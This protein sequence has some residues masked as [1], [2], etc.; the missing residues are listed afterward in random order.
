MHGLMRGQWRSAQVHER[1]WVCKL[2]SEAD[3]AEML[4][5]ASRGNSPLLYSTV[6]RC[7]LARLVFSERL[8]SMT[9]ARSERGTGC[10][11]DKLT[12]V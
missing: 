10:F 5:L 11:P 2:P 1:A 8:T 3:R 12:T 6:I 7:D 4:S 9:L